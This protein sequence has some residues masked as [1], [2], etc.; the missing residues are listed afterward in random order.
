[1]GFGRATETLFDVTPR[2]RRDAESA[3]SKIHG[4][5][6]AR[7]FAA[8]GIAPRDLAPPKIK[9]PV[10]VIRNFRTIVDA[11]LRQQR[12][13]AFD[14]ERRSRPILAVAVFG[15]HDLAR[16][17]R[18]IEDFIRRFLIRQ[19]PVL[20]Q[21]VQDIEFGKKVCDDSTLQNFI[22]TVRKAFVERSDDEGHEGESLIVIQI[23]GLIEVEELDHPIGVS[24][25]DLPVLP[26]RRQAEVRGK[27]A[28]RR[29]GRE[30]AVLSFE[31]QERYLKSVVSL[32]NEMTRRQLI[33]L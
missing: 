26:N 11:L 10:A 13:R 30:S 23:P 2:V 7:K 12:L 8:A 22:S 20:N 25:F 4:L 27:P 15:L 28:N 33:R 9:G 3:L 14:R 1:M 24:G 5:I 31:G 32:T 6:D 16:D 21:A 18:E 19:C 17:R 29:P